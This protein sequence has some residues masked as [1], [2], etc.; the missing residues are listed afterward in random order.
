MSKIHIPRQLLGLLI[1]AIGVTVLTSALSFALLR[2]TSR[3]A[4][5]FTGASLTKMEGTYALL[6]TLGDQQNSLLRLLGLKDPDEMEKALLAFQAR[7]G[8]VVK[9]VTATGD[10]G[11]EIRARL[12]VITN[13]E[14][15]IVDELLKGNTSLAFEKFIGTATAEYEAVHDAI[16]KYHHGVSKATNTE[17]EHQSA[18]SETSLWWRFGIVG[19]LLLGVLAYGWF[20]RRQITSNLNRVAEDL[21]EISRRVAENA[22][23]ISATSQS[24]AEGASEQAASLEET[25]ASLEEMASM[26]S[27]NSESSRTAKELTSQARQSAALGT[28]DIQQMAS[29]MEAIKTSGSNIAKIVKTI[30]EIAFQTNILALNAAVEAARAGEAGA[31]FAVVADE[32]RNLAQRSAIA[33][34]ETA[35]KIHDSIQKSGHAAD[36]SNKIAARLTEIADKTKHIDDLVAGISTA[37][38]EQSQGI[39]QINAAVTQVDKVTQGNAAAAEESASAMIELQNQALSMQ[40]AVDDLQSMVGRAGTVPSTSQNLAG[41]GSAAAQQASATNPAASGTAPQK[42]GAEHHGVNETISDSSAAS[43][44]KS[45][46][47]SSGDWKDF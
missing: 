22:A 25:G 36:I 3:N 18:R 26:T 23:Q 7:Q 43:R 5:K 13:T 42:P 28:E 4:S 17:L 34:R 21:S 38:I 33:S 30:D 41:K 47:S 12:A 46:A 14:K 45:P 40:H 37:S 6:Q 39:S 24:L 31:G 29:A 9:L 16:S 27:R 2:Q 35:E 19:V 32:V 10:D 20:I 11:A 1:V 44:G 8:N 15:S